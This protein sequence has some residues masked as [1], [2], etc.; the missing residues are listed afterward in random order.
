MQSKTLPSIQS[1]KPNFIGDQE[2]VRQRQNSVLVVGAG[3]IGILLGASLLQAG[4][5][6]TFAGRRQSDYTYSLQKNGVSVVYADG[7][8]FEIS[9]SQE[10]VNFV[11]TQTPL[12]RVFNIV[13][14]AVK[15][16]HLAAV[17][18]YVRAHSDSDTIIIQ[19]QNGIPYWW[20]KD[21][22]YYNSLN[23]TIHQHLGN[24]RRDSF[25]SRR[26]LESV[27]PDGKILATLG[28]RVIVGCVVKAPCSKTN[29]QVR[30][31]KPAKA[32]LGL[33][34]AKRDRPFEGKIKHLSNLFNQFGLQTQYSRNIRAEVCNKLAVNAT[35]NVLSALTGCLTSELTAHTHSNNLIKTIL[36]EIN[37]VF[38]VYGIPLSQLP[39]EERLYAYITQPGS[40]KHLPSLAQDF[41][42]HRL[43]EISLIGAPVEMARLANLATP[44]LDSLAELLEL[45]QKYASTGLS[46][47]FHLL[48][49]SHSLG[50]YVLRE[51][52]WRTLNLP[53][54]QLPLILNY[55]VRVNQ[56]ALQPKYPSSQSQSPT[57]E[58]SYSHW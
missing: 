58:F 57:F 3:S 38:R 5:R 37:G 47:K 15:S 44:T 55:L 56:S 10:Q 39:T 14:V 19:A 31:K 32:I 29:T 46:S 40:Q 28:D 53:L 27:D 2:G 33:V 34:D 17:A 20:F 8:K 12:N 7:S 52:V 54:N 23:R 18:S 35:T 16:H 50:L 24:S 51:E 6:V 49:F 1:I 26:W 11:D 30:V 22:D 25:A 4:C 45:G 41:A 48:D 36:W 21:S 42:Q 13:I 9:P 43:G